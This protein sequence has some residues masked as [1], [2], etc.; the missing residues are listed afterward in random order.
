MW[1]WLKV[2]ARRPSRNRQ[3]R[4]WL[5][6]LPR[7]LRVLRT[8]LHR[9]RRMCGRQLRVLVLALL[10]PLLW[11]DVP[12]P[13][14]VLVHEKAQ[15]W[16]RPRLG[17]T[18]PFLSLSPPPWLRLRLRLCL[19]CR[20]GWPSRPSLR[21]LRSGRWCLRCTQIACAVIQGQDSSQRPQH[22]PHAI[23]GW[24]W[25]VCPLACGARFFLF[26]SHAHYLKNSKR[27]RERLSWR[28]WY[29]WR[30]L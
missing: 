12:V 28:Q 21:P 3:C 25:R 26:E 24:P 6:L 13:A 9:R 5:L 14:P 30:H 2:E 20:P 1:L 4:Q 22:D 10:R 17:G 27:A 29:P 8:Q 11:L 19:R 18:A 23:V 16:P 7:L 15:S